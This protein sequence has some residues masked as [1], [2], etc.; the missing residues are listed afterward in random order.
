[1]K[2]RKNLLR[3]GRERQKGRGEESQVAGDALR[4]IGRIPP[5]V[6]FTSN[7]AS[8]DDVIPQVRAN[9][10]RTLQMD[11]QFRMR[12]LN[13]EAC[14][15]Y[16]GEH[17]KQQYVGMF[18]SEK[19]GSFRGDICRTAVLYREGGFYT[20]LDLQLRIPLS[21]MVDNTT[22][23]MSAYTADGA[24]LNAIIAVPP[25]SEVM[26][27][28][29]HE[30]LKWYSGL[31]KKYATYEEGTTSEWMGPL[32]LMRGLRTVANKECPGTTLVSYEK[33]QFTCGRYHLVMYQEGQ[34]DCTNPEE[35]PEKRKQ[36]EFL[37]VK[38]G[39]YE[40]RG[41]YHDRKLV[42]WPRFEECKDWGCQ[43]GGWD[44]RQEED[45]VP[46]MN[47]MTSKSHEM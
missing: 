19:R 45:I 15:Q 14:L 6:I 40:P 28:T 37:G 42:A 21:Q 46:R 17:F 1:M 25:H 2:V 7:R 23:F 4:R 29:L 31:A 8:L 32:T 33:H 22:S 11:P 43:T 26:R 12:W 16:L 9:V 10:M 34:L 30:L 38:F 39:L 3:A 20:D 24:I 41:G 47:W 36:S 18:A 35:C 27:E 5:Q 13:D 44:E